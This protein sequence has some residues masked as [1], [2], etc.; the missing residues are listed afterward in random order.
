MKKFFLFRREQLSLFSSNSSD[1]GAGL[2]VLAIPA[3][4]LSFM[5]AGIGSVQF[6]FDDAS[7][8]DYITLP[9][10]DVI[11][12]T[13][14]IVSCKEGKEVDL[15]VSVMNFISSDSKKNLL[16][17][18]A[19]NQESTLNEAKVE[20]F[21]DISSIINSAP[22]N[23]ITQETDV[24]TH[25]IAGVDFLASV[26]L[27]VVDY[28]HE[29]ITQSDG[30]H[31]STWANDSN[32]TGGS[33]YDSTDQGTP[34]V[35]AEDPGDTSY[36]NTKS[37]FISAGNFFRLANDLVIHQD[38][39]VY[40][41]FGLPLYTN[42]HELY[43]SRNGTA[44]FTNGKFNLVSIIHDAMTGLPASV[45]TDNKDGGSVSY[46][47]P[48]PNLEIDVTKGQSAYVFVIRRDVN[49]NLYVHNYNGDIIA[50]IPAKKGGLL[51]TSG[52]TDG[53]LLIKTFGG[54]YPNYLFKGFL[55]RFGVIEKDIGF[56]ASRKIAQNLY[57][58]YAYN[59][60]FN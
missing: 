28:N 26:N 43:G 55:S 10:S 3:D 8:Y 25:V 11:D 39:T 57:K 41:A 42:V 31:I 58:K 29:G 50:V 9:D 36:I 14:V 24:S 16:R 13:H 2:A 38:Y 15:M 51:S 56:N 17:F 44:G 30:Q 7:V 27:P 20:G 45:R 4:K 35:T 21:E 33:T 53:D 5:T 32:A 49:F 52:R 22:V 6:N 34:N 54:I 12:K 46:Q 19:V 37:A 40:C 48:D 59:P 47:L 1:D 23:I 18:D 60:N